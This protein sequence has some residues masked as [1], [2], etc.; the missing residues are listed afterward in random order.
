[1]CVAGLTMPT[2]MHK[3][4]QILS[5]AMTVW[6]CIVL[7]CGVAIR[8]SVLPQN[9]TV[10]TNPTRRGTHHLHSPSPRAIAPNN[11][12]CNDGTEVHCV[13]VC[14]CRR[15]G[16]AACCSAML[17]CVAVCCSRALQC[18]PSPHAGARPK[19]I[20]CDNSTVWCSVSLQ[21]VAVHNRCNLH[22]S[23]APH[24]GARPN[25]VTCD[26][27]MD[28]IEEYT[29]RSPPHTLLSTSSGG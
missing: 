10:L 5:S 23:P 14:C 24:A 28:D 26:D 2:H 7:Q 4:V 25:N 17:Q 18:V 19:S 9:T 3:R 16:V 22:S 8:C 11:G 13:A 20:M 1:M 29:S 27:G 15:Y 6:S 21:Y 12:A